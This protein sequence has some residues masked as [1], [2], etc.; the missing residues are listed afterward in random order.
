MHLVWFE[1][2]PERLY[3]RGAKEV[4]IKHAIRELKII[5]GF[6]EIDYGNTEHVYERSDLIG[7]FQFRICNVRV[8]KNIHV[9]YKQVFS[10]LNDW[11]VGQ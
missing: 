11:G 1:F 7:Q 4:I 9:Q 10:D 2:Y 3:I 8:H 6:V 5:T